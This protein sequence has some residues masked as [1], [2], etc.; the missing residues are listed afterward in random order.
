MHLLASIKYRVKRLVYKQG[1][2]DLA[3]L[4]LVSEHWIPR[5]DGFPDVGITGPMYVSCSLRVYGVRGPV[6]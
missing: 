4:E 1:I 6:R 2:H 3:P 5:S